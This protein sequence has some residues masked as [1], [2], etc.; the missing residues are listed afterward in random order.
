[1]PQILGMK[2]IQ[3][4]GGRHLRPVKTIGGRE[5]Y[6]TFTDDNS[7]FTKLYLQ[8]AKDE[9]FTSYKT[10]EADLLRQKGVHVKKLHS[11]RGGEYLSKEFSDHLAKSGTKRNLTVHDTPEHNRVAERLNRTLLEKVRAIL[12]GSGLPKFLWGEAVKH[13]IWLKNRSSTKVFEGKTPFEVYE[14]TKPNLSGLPEFGCKVWV[15]RPERSKLDGRAV[16]G[17]WVGYDENS[18]GHRIYSPEKRSVS[19]QR[20][21]KFSPDE[22][23]IY[24]PRTDTLEGERKRIEHETSGE[25]PSEIVDPLGDDFDKSIESRPK[26]A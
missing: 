1:M 15:H 7:R 6:S 8:R 16:E 2:F 21:V 18:S 12:H 24:L 14:G 3:M 26:R 4:Y 19:I 20:S 17:R 23:N 13:A 11:D 10:Y 5:Y 25:R 9:T 22:A